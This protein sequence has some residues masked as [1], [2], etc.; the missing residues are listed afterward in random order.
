MNSVAALMM[1]H[2]TEGTTG[3]MPA[4]IWPLDVFQEKVAEQCADSMQS[5]YVAVAFFV[6]SGF[7]WRYD[8]G[9]CG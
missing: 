3:P 4:Y 9:A 1:S 8:G 5:G 6:E 2:N 7:G